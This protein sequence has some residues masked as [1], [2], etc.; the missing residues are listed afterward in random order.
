[1]ASQLTFLHLHLFIWKMGDLCLIRLKLRLLP[2]RW[3]SLVS[4]KVSV[5]LSFLL[6][7]PS[8]SM[9]FTLRQHRVAESQEELSLWGTPSSANTLCAM[10]E[11]VSGPQFAH[12][13]DEE[14][15]Y[16]WR[17]DYWHRNGPNSQDPLSRCGLGACVHDLYFSL[18]L[19]AQKADPRESLSA[20]LPPSVPFFLPFF[21]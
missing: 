2:S 8:H 7:R 13:Q 12:L 18:F 14:D 3:F 15:D 11:L 16:R 4:L 19:A 17:R 6:S 10:G 21:S 20:C 9:W 5:F 1:M